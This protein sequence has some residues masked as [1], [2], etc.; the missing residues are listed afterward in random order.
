MLVEVRHRRLVGQVDP[1]LHAGEVAAAEHAVVLARRAPCRQHVRLDARRQLGELA[2]EA[3]PAGDLEGDP[4]DLPRPLRHGER[5]VDPADLEHEDPGGAELHR[6]P[7]RDRVHDAAVQ[8]VLVA[9]LRRRQQP[10]DGGARDDG[11]DDRAGVEP[12]LGGPLDARGAHLEPDRQL[13]EGEVAELVDQRLL[14]RRRGPEVGARRD[15]PTY[16]AQRAV[17]VHLGA[18][19]GAAPQ[20]DQLGDDRG[21]RVAGDHGAV[22]RADAGAEHQ[23]G[24]DVA[25]EERPQHADL[26]R[27]EDAA[28]AEHEGGGHG[29]VTQSRMPRA[30]GSRR[31]PS[32]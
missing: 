10:G 8:V 2:V 4:G 18:G 32:A 20:L 13:L 31:V 12:V 14:E 30:R 28:A 19:R 25:L 22:E 11:V 26:D 5:P 15:G 17:A 6:T 23:V 3:V 29:A 9:D 1:F 21:V 24:D 7:E 27:A 16:G